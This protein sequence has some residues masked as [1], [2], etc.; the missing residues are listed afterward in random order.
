M[1]D[2]ELVTKKE[3]MDLIKIKSVNTIKSYIKEGMPVATKKPLRFNYND[4]IDWMNR[5]E[6]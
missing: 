4:V 6:K 5:E 2:K 1:E 3:L